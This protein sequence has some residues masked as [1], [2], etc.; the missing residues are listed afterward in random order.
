MC[1]NAEVSLLTY[2][3][4][5]V[6]CSIL[7]L[8]KNINYKPEALFL[9]WVVQMQLI[10]F[11]LW[12]NQPSGQLLGIN[13]CNTINRYTSKIG[14]LINNSEPLILWIA[15][16]LFSK[17]KLPVWLHG[18]ML[19]YMSSSV[20]YNYNIDDSCTT[21]TVESLPHLKWK[22][23]NGSYSFIFYTFFLLCCILLSIYGLEHGYHLAF[24][25]LISF[26]LSYSIYK[27]THAIGAMWCF[28][29]A[30]APF[31][32]PLIYKIKFL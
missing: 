16:I 14:L 20:L 5:L 9:F 23:N 32:L 19:L 30:F 12:K 8:D 31:L 18:I 7:F 25:F 17:K 28:F 4:G 10:E 13:S 26:I 29:A 24:V 27:K 6:G 2:V 11:V 21:T 15:I 1:F 22:W 3:V